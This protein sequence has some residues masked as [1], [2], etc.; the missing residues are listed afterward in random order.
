MIIIIIS[1]AEIF[2]GAFS[3]SQNFLRSSTT[4]PMIRM[5]RD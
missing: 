1:P 5:G 3:F 4:L 2:S